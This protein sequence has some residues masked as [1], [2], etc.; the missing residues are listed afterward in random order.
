MKGTQ[1]FLEFKK[2]GKNVEKFFQTFYLFPRFFFSKFFDL[3][4]LI[5]KKHFIILQNYEKGI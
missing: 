5:K 3:I 2:K 4:I 1:D